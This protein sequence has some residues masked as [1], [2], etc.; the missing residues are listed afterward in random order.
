MAVSDNVQ[1]GSERSEWKV[2]CDVLRTKTIL[3]RTEEEMSKFLTLISR[4]R[5]FS[6]LPYECRLA[7]SKV[8]YYEREPKK[9]VDLISHFD[10]H[11]YTGPWRLILWGA[12]EMKAVSI[13]GKTYFDYCKGDYFG[14]D[15]TLKALP[16][17]ASFTTKEDGCEF[18]CLHREDYI[19]LLQ[20]QEEKELTQRVQYFK[21]LLVPAFASWTAVQL[22]ELAKS[23]Y[24]RKYTSRQVIVR[25]NEHGADMFF[26]VQGECRVVR[27][28]EILKGTAGHMKKMVKL[29]ELAVLQPGEYFGELAPYG[30][31]VDLNNKHRAEA[32]KT[33][34]GNSRDATAG[35]K[36]PIA[37][38]L[39][40]PINIDN[41][42]DGD[43]SDPDTGG[44][45]SQAPEQ[46][47]ARQATVFS[48][49][50]LRLL[51]LPID[52]LRE[53]LVGNPLQRMREYAKGY[54]TANEIRTQYTIQHDWTAFKMNLVSD[55]I[56]S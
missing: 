5:V 55:I 16:G 37:K 8:A 50:P 39:L 54:P 27:E 9:S 43:N 19:S 32:N 35:G 13:P 21:N 30:I 56:S 40:P 31:Q 47:G 36:H 33:N 14:D 20:F 15:L 2:C 4:Q 17:G 38:K 18:L 23:V 1:L 46:V 22:R 53:L 6:H 34:S 48:H 52:A 45:S 51:V 12:V 24:P 26:I 28:I 42:S 29:L 44:V 7:I 49:T 41:D 11:K 10:V 25:E 3:E